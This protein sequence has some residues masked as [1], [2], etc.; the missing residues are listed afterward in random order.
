MVHDRWGCVSCIQT[1]R[2][3]VTDQQSSHGQPGVSQ[4]TAEWRP[5]SADRRRRRLSAQLIS[6]YP[7]GGSDAKVAQLICCRCPAEQLLS[8]EELVAVVGKWATQKA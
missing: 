7:V 2:L 1:P 4:G 5:F 3:T 6:S 8:A